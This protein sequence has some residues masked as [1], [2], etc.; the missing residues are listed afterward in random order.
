MISYAINVLQIELSKVENSI[1]KQEKI[2]EKVKEKLSEADSLQS[3][4]NEF[5]GKLNDLSVAN[6]LAILE[7]NLAKIRIYYSYDLL[8]HEQEKWEGLVN[9]RKEL[10]NAIDF[11]RHD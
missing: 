3:S 9:Q 7:V 2:I 6:K 8:R 4:I 10:Q 5:F 11:L 1:C